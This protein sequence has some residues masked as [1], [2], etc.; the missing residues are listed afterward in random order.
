MK[1]I[2]G[3]R[4][5]SL[6]RRKS[7]KADD[8]A[9][10]GP[11]KT[12]IKQGM[13][14]DNII[15]QEGVKDFLTKIHQKGKV[16]HALFFVGPE[17]C[18]HLPMALAYA[19]QLLCDE[20]DIACCLKADHLQHPD[21][22]FVFPIATTDTVK[23]HPVSALFLSEWRIFLQK[24]PYG[25]LFDWLSHIGVENKQGQIGVEDTQEINKAVHMKSYEGG[26]KVIVLWIPE[27]L[28][29]SAAN[30]LLKILEEPPLK[31]IFLFVGENE[32]GVL[33]TIRSRMQT[34]RFKR[35]SSQEIQIALQEQFQI[36]IG[37]AEKIAH[38]AEGDWNKALELVQ[39]LQENN[40]EKYFITWIRNAFLAKKHPQVLKEL[41]QWSETLHAWGR[42]R[43]KQFLIYCLQMFR[44]AL[45][46]H[47]QIEGL[48][49]VPL[50][51]KDFQWENFVS[52]IHGK[53]IE[54]IID[55]LNTAIYHI[56]RNASAKMVL[57]DLSIQ[58]TR[59][60]HR[61]P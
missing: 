21:L 10:L 9:Y 49:F 23:S 20:H 47:Y 31:T 5:G 4:F 29:P 35:L 58:I 12:F 22:N 14:F 52:F 8:N 44:Q 46:H 39:M 30:K 13:N 18:G 41:V 3:Q 1:I 43:Q 36:E 59:Y 61:I 2:G 6:P 34:V 11:R 57:L 28:H 25:S 33:P 19:K 45:L 26:N 53:N 38:Q 37:R 50:V 56:E 17:G 16:P 48:H 7:R 54:D 27:R 15:G 24:K 32:S 60:L 51:S 42:E 55:S 40:F